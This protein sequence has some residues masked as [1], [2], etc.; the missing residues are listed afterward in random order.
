[1]E[2]ILTMTVRKGNRIPLNY[3][4]PLASWVYRVI[5]QADQS[6]SEFLHEK[7][8][9]ASGRT[10]KLFTFSQLDFKPYIIEN[11]AIR[12]LGNTLS[13]NVRFF[14]DSS[15]EHF[16]TGLFR[17]QHF[18]LGDRDHQVAM[19]VTNIQTVPAPHFNTTQRYHCLSPIVASTKRDD[20]SVAY[21][22][23]ADPRFGKILLKNLQRKKMAAVPEGFE[24]EETPVT[25]HFRL[26]NTPR[27]KGIEIKAGTRE[28]TKVI[29]HLFHFELTAPVEFHEVGYY[30]GF[31]EKNSMGFGCVELLKSP[32]Q[33]RRI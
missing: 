2:L 1:M 5:G 29:G 10:Y 6:Y 20:G 4:Y 28:A 23:P 32:I 14:V 12:V 8:H 16:I 7:G 26:L 22:S 30:A 24:H 18:E 27:K 19:E 33:T 15:M 9:A 21:L 13:L 31:G 17:Q 11:S 25:G 3:Q